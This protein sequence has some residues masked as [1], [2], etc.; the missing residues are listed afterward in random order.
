MAK[1]TNPAKD[2][3]R[4]AALTARDAMPAEMRQAAAQTVAERA[5][6]APVQ[7][8]TIISGFMPIGSEINPIPL[9]RRL[10]DQGAKLALPVVIGRG[11]PLAMR[12]WTFGE[13]LIEQQWNIKIPRPEAMEVDPDILLV[14]L[15]AFDRTGHRIGYGAGY[16][17]LT[18]GGLRARKRIVAI[19]LA[20]AVQEVAAVPASAHDERLDFLM[21]ERETIDFRASRAG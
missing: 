19:G 2:A 6:P 20:F 18:I 17:D 7:P 13:P 3:L 8:G 5:F 1:P 16:Y 12:A 11:K 4:K 9:M 15:A 14:P 21:T 10:A